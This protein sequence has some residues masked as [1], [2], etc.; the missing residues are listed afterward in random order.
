MN[1]REFLE[2]LSATAL[3][4]GGATTNAAPAG[5]DAEFDPTEKSLTQLSDAQ[6]KGAVSAETL[7]HSYLRRI[8]RYD[9]QGP[10]LGAVLAGNPDALN[11]ARALDVERRAG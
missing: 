2:T 7:T 6:A 8:E 5:T 1:R 3:A 9:R 10:K 4:A 11:A